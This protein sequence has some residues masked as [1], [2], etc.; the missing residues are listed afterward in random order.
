MSDQDE[1]GFSFQDNRR[2]DPETFAVREPQT[3]A[4]EGVEANVEVIIWRLS[5]HIWHV[6]PLRIQGKFAQSLCECHD[7]INSLSA[8]LKVR[9]LEH[10]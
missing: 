9:W 1:S 4:P 6:I 5:E 8:V 3:P 2:I 10:R 7:N